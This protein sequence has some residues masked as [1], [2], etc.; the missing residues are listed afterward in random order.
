MSRKVSCVI[1]NFIMYQPKV[2]VDKLNVVKVFEPDVSSVSPSSTNIYIIVTLYFFSLGRRRLKL[3][4][5]GD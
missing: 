2:D 4:S 1:N 3:V 5:H